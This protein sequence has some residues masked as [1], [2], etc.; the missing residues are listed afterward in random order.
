MRRG[1]TRASRL[2]RRLL[3]LPVGVLLAAL[4]LEV[5][6]RAVGHWVPDPTWYVGELENRP[7]ENFVPDPDTG[8]RM[9]SDHRFTRPAA[10]VEI[11]Y[12]SDGE[13]FR[14]SA[15]P[16]ASG[17]DALVAFVGDSQTW[18]FGVPFEASFGERIGE[19]LGLR[20]ANFSQPGFGIDQ[21][22]LA[23][24][25]QAL[26]REPDLIVVGVFRDDFSRSLQAYRF[27]EGFNKPTFVLD[28]GELRRRTEGDRDGAAT[29]WLQRRSH[30]YTLLSEKLRSGGILE[31]DST[32]LDL[33]EALLR[34]MRDDARAAGVPI[35]FVRIPR[36]LGTRFEALDAIMGRLGA[37]Y[38]DPA[39]TPPEETELY[40]ADRH[41]NEAGHRWVAD[42]V[43]R[44]IAANEPELT[45]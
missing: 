23:L 44:W 15:S 8:W 41:L 6:L 20:T 35:L 19:R 24:R 42:C 37:E 43:E 29:V 5:A 16:R 18:G 26:P 13:G 38:V 33:N 36:D 45:R 7:S 17:R 28:G 3:A 14:R 9:R 21:V 39:R 22:G 40:Y 31:P 4:A 30:L 25:H 1:A 27:V 10:G 2:G 32:W 11:E 34:R 12:L